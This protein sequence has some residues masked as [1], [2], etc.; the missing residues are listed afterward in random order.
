MPAPN[1]PTNTAMDARAAKKDAARTRFLGVY[2]K[3]RAELVGQFQK[4]SMSQDAIEWFERVGPHVSVTSSMPLM[5]LQ[6]LDYNTPH[7]KLNRGLSVV[8]T[9]AILKG[10]E[11]SEQEY[12]RA[13]VLGW[14]IELVRSF[15][16]KPPLAP[17]SLISDLDPCGCSFL[18][19]PR[20]PF[21]PVQ[22]FLS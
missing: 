5:A 17:A 4:E 12:F 6:N 22:Y 8:D 13:A 2:D 3:L 9:A 18:P 7:G 19:F 20:S 16:P 15:L 1:I 11:L 14:C 21:I 10:S